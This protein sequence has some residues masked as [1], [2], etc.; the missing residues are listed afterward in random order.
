MALF[1]KAGYKGGLLFVSI[2]EP[3]K[4]PSSY[5]EAFET[6][7]RSPGMAER[8]TDVS[9]KTMLNRAHVEGTKLKSQLLVARNAA[10]SELEDALSDPVLARGVPVY[11][12][13]F[14]GSMK[15]AAKELQLNLDHTSAM[16]AEMSRLSN[17]D[18]K[19]FEIDGKFRTQ[20][21][22]VDRYSLLLTVSR[23]DTRSFQPLNA[24]PM[25]ASCT[26]RQTI[27]PHNVPNADCII[28]L[29][30]STTHLRLQRP[31][32]R[33][34]DL[35]D[36]PPPVIVE[37]P[38]PADAA[39]ADGAVGGSKRTGHESKQRHKKGRV[40]CRLKAATPIKAG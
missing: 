1:T 19:Q 7:F 17:R 35:Q 2:W 8:K 13:R 31:V 23:D 15:E 21:M 3:R 36:L 40:H 29:P 39:A 10:V 18:Q 38:D 11:K 5:C 26:V 16:A 33:F 14:K 4:L 32:A 34:S 22:V 9:H 25:C 12:E 27:C 30:P 28:A 24:N 6:P 20:D 37:L